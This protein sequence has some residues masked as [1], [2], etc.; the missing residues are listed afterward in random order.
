MT[1]SIPPP[2]TT[3]NKTTTTKQATDLDT[4]PRHDQPTTHTSAKLA[5]LERQRRVGIDL[6][7]A[8]RKLYPEPFPG[9]DDDRATAWPPISTDEKVTTAIDDG[10]P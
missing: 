7:P 3:T 4:N 8:A 2:T 9:Q 1:P 10:Q 6:N 5:R